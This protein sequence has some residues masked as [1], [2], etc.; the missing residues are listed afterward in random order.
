MTTNRGDP[1]QL[2]VTVTATRPA[3]APSNGI[4]QIQFGQATNAIVDINNQSKNGGNLTA[5]SAAGTEKVTFAV[6]RSPSNASTT[7]V[8][9]TVTDD[10][11]EWRSFVGGGASA[12]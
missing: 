2:L 8:P 10:C 1:G 4:S 6:R 12:F 7:T 3:S 9:F 5:Y 11:G